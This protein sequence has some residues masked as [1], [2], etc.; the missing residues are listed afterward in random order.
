MFTIP[1]NS[2]DKITQKKERKLAH[3]ETNTER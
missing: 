1:D 3:R 2:I